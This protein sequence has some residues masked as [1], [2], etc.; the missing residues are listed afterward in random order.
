MNTK[1]DIKF[2]LTQ[3]QKV[4]CRDCREGSHYT[5]FSFEIK[6]SVMLPQGF[7]RFKPKEKPK[8]CFILKSIV[9][10]EMFCLIAAK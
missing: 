1:A 3:I 4:R 10:I 6:H 8:I 2:F 5:M 7:A 9:K